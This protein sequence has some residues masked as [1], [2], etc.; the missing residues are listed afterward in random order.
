MPRVSRHCISD[1]SRTDSDRLCCGLLPFGKSRRPLVQSARMGFTLK[2]TH[3]ILGIVLGILCSCAVKENR[4]AGVGEDASGEVSTSDA[5]GAACIFNGDQCSARSADRICCPVSS[6]R[7]DTVRHCL[8][9][10]VSSD[11]EL[12]CRSTRER[13]CSSLPRSQ[14]FHFR[15]PSGEEGYL[16]TSS[17]WMVESTDRWFLEP[18]SPSMTSEFTGFVS[19]D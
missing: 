11:V 6:R 3:R 17:V 10:A 19:C 13:I 7:V 8:A 14:C 4:D 16:I 15:A 18:C 5:T 9:E 2:F 12:N 1:S